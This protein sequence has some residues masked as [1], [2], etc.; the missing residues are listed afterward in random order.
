MGKIVFNL[1]SNALKFTHKGKIQ[2]II[3]QKNRSVE[4]RVK[5][6]G[7]GIP[8]KN[9]DRIFEKYI[10]VEDT[11][12]RCKEGTGIGLPLV[13]ELVWAHKGI[14]KVRSEVGVGSEFI[15]SIPKGKSHLNQK[16]IYESSKQL[17]SDSLGEKFTEE[18]SGWL[19][20]DLGT[21]RRKEREF[22]HRTGIRVLIVD[23]NADMRQYLTGVFSERYT[24]LALEHGR[25][26]V[27]FLEKGGQTDLIISDVM[28]P[29]MN[30]YELVDFL[31]SNRKYRH[32]PVVMLSA[33]ATEEAKIKGL[34]LGADYYLYKPFSAGELNAVVNASIR[35]LTMVSQRL[36]T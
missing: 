26:V 20:Q 5:D 12:G 3:H 21:K 32:I 19:P 7:I 15:V 13:R 33:K 27:D 34:D 22:R 4:F 14:I 35:K 36:P 10:R 11:N 28:M 8:D 24:V 9:I 30:G 18:V 29:Q 6:T 2:L 17:P 31:K 25:Q 16:H 23:D 1:V